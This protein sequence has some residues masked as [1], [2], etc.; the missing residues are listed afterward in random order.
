PDLIRQ[1]SH[2]SIQ[3]PLWIAGSSPVM[4]NEVWQLID[5]KE[6]II[7][8]DSKRSCV[9]NDPQRGVIASGAK[10]SRRRPPERW[11]WIAA[12]AGAGS[13]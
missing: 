6:F 13:Q 12:P 3:A 8:S 2:R 5:L 7:E 4:T 1:S 10:P 11:L 9:E